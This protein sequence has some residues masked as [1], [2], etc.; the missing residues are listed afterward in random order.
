MEWASFIKTLGQSLSYP[1]F[2][3]GF[4]LVALFAHSRFASSEAGSE[5]EDPRVRSRSFTTR[6]RYGLSAIVYIVFFEFG[7]GL[8]VGIGSFPFLQGILEKWI[9]SL[10]ISPDPEATVGTPTWA[11]LMVTAVLPATPGF[12]GADRKF[13][14]ALHN[15]ASIPYKAQ[16]LAREILENLPVEFFNSTRNLDPEEH[17]E[18]E[19]RAKH[20][21]QQLS[22][23]L[24]AVEQLQDSTVSGNN[25]NSYRKFFEFDYRDIWNDIR[26]KKKH[27]E[28]WLD[29]PE[30]VA[31]VVSRERGILLTSAS[32][33]LS[34]ALLLNESS[35]RTA[36]GLIRDKLGIESLP[37]LKFD[38]KLEQIYISILLALILT[39]I[40]GLVALGFVLP[41]K[42]DGITGDMVKAIVFWLPFTALTMVVPFIFAAGIRLY[43]MDR[44]Q[45]GREVLF[46]DQ[47]LGVIYLFMFTFAVGVIP[48][49]LGMVTGNY[50]LDKNWVMQV[51]PSG[52]TPAVVAVLFYFLS[53]RHL[54]KVQWI[55]AALDVVIFSVAAGIM[56]WLTA[57]VAIKAGL[58]IEITMKIDGITNEV[59]L[60]VSPVTHAVMVGVIGAIQC[61]ISRAS[62]M[63]PAEA[64]S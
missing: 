31:P 12:D 49:L 52:A 37:R 27:M 29:S 38:F 4:F 40:G 44:I 7:Y 6:F 2:W 16:G 35:E 56:A 17:E 54:F 39:F 13:R 47:L 46:E 26:Q 63:A 59:L 9:G 3:V 10:Q 8:L 43:F 61:L 55:D 24:E 15:F 22:W 48:T 53:S 25:A 58:D 41:D 45:S 51:M 11:T 36:R 19:I 18:E 57:V 23:S 28:K 60:V 1:T 14:R 34:C 21:A 50:D 64:E 42:W 20:E 30:S 62:L 32:R 33:F 5:K